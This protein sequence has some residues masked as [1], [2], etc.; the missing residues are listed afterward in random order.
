MNAATKMNGL[1]QSALGFWNER[2]KRERTL[3]SAAAVIIV[4][5]LFYLLL[6]DP[7]LSGRQNLEKALPAL[8]QQAA[9]LHAMAKDA[10]GAGGKAAAPVPELTRE[11]LEASLQSKGLKP[12]SVVLAGEQTKVQLSS[13]SFA[14]LVEW[15]DEMQR[16]A[17]L[18]VIEA[19]VEAQAKPDTV[20][21][22]LTLR[23]QKGE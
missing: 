6:I 11:R 2:N 20:N 13:I 4:L 14:A 5:G 10:A 1:M 19:N 7:A 12:Q 3:L 15:L 9:E 21:A 23:Q 22:T 16:T 17:R 18:S 8:R